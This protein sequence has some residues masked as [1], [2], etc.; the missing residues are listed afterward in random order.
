MVRRLSGAAGGQ[1]SDAAKDRSGL[2]VKAKR[3][4][5]TGKPDADVEMRRKAETHLFAQAGDDLPFKFY[6]EECEGE[7]RAALETVIGEMVSVEIWRTVTLLHPKKPDDPKIAPVLRE[8]RLQRVFQGTIRKLILA[9]RQ[10]APEQLARFI[11]RVLNRR[12][13][14]QVPAGLP[15]FDFPR[16]FNAQRRRSIIRLLLRLPRHLNA[17]HRQRLRRYDRVLCAVVFRQELRPALVQLAHE[18]KPGVLKRA[19]EACFRLVGNNATPSLTASVT[20]F[21]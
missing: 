21:F 9:D 16:H 8:V 15:F 6:P 1:C 11:S 10:H 14:P 12:N 2:I 18:G 19:L 4:S 17:A 13:W 7:L 20:R 5:A 3:P